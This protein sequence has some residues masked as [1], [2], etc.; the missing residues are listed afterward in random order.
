M[1][2]FGSSETVV[3]RAQFLAFAV[4][5]PTGTHRRL[6]RSHTTGFAVGSSPTSASTNTLIE[7]LLNAIA[8]VAPVRSGTGERSGGRVDR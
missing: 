2:L 3:T 4:A 5:N 8:A 6:V 7:K 1:R